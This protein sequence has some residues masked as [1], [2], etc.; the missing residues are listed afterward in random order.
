MPEVTSV[1]K[2][3]VE[4]KLVFCLNPGQVTGN[5]YF[6]TEFGRALLK[7]GFEVKVEPLH[8]RVSWNAYS[9]VVRAKTRRLIVIE[10]SSTFYQT[11]A[12]AGT[13]AR[14]RRRLIAKESLGLKT[15]IRTLKDL[16]RGCIVECIGFTEIFNR[17]IYALS[18]SGK[19]IADQL[20][21]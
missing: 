15:V 1:I 14:I 18:E 19:L 7:K 10:L 5:L 17:R 2:Q 13:A 21:K 11:N 8:H 4:K 12:E 3:L 6:P 16:E 9:Y 20:A